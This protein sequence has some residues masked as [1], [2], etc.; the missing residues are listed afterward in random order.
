MTMY[1]E[2]LSV[3]ELTPALL[4]CQIL[5]KKGRTVINK[6]IKYMNDSV[7]SHSSIN[8]KSIF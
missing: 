5:A 2:A 4:E 6:R 3:Q 8:N 1:L 7:F